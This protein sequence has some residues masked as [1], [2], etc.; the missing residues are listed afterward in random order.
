M[1]RASTIRRLVALPLSVLAFATPALPAHAATTSVTI[2]GNLQ[3]ELGCPGDWQPECAATHLAFD[4]ADDVW[5]G[6]FSVP[7][8]N[9]EYKAVLNN[10]WDENYGAKATRNGSNIP[11]NLGAAAAVKFYFDDKS[12]W[13]TNNVSTRIVTAPGSFQSELGC[14]GDWD[15]SCLRSWLQD[16][17]DD[18]IFEFITT[19]IPVGSYEV[20]AAI[21]ES[22]YENYG[23]GGFQNGANIPF[24][25][26]F[27]GASVLFSFN[28]ERDFLTVTVEP[29]TVP[30]PT[31]LALLGLGLAGLAATRRRKQ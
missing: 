4:A 20:K 7:A 10:S 24:S 1:K 17:D 27:A 29:A 21:N 9:W 23:A 19:A 12:N 11:L 8:G 6:V 2:A 25:V 5:Q 28:S 15:P 26:P 30:E 13:V 18:G 22:W 31:T 16:I 14:G 3:S